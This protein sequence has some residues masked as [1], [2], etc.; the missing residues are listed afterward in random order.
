MRFS[1]WRQRLS[2]P[3][4]RLVA[5]MAVLAVGCA[6]IAAPAAPT[7]PA[8]PTAPA[9]ASLNASVEPALP[10]QPIDLP[11]TIP[12]IESPTADVT[13]TAVA[14]PPTSKPTKRPRKTATPTPDAVDLDVSSNA[15][16]IAAHSDDPVAGYHVDVTF[17][18]TNSGSDRARKFTVAVTCLGYTLTQDVFGGLD[19]G[20]GYDI[21]FGFY[22][23]I[24][25]DKNYARIVV[26]ST[27][28]LAETDEGNN[29]R[30]ISN[31]PGNCG[32]P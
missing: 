28:R 26:D 12:T 6:N 29:E 2:L 15:P 32:R 9:L 17:T 5:V 24:P 16:Y 7:L 30:E 10:T 1:E 8:V 14:Q 4:A 21:S 19:P 13:A 23:S 3:R 25:A 22:A 11:T 20:E 31:S 18:V 27:D